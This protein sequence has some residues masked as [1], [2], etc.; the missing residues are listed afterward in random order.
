MRWLLPLVARL[1]TRTL[2]IVCG[3]L[4][5]IDMVVPDPV[6]FVDELFLGLA[7]VLLTRW[8]TRGR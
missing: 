2:A 5:V 6:P 3:T 8:G 1:G 4:F 7:T